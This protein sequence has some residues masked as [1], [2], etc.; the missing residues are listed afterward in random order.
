MVENEKKAAAN[1]KESEA[2]PEQALD[3]VAMGVSPSYGTFAQATGESPRLDQKLQAIKMGVYDNGAD[4]TG[5][6][7]AENE[8]ELRARMEAAKKYEELQNAIVEEREK[9]AE[10]EAKAD[11][12][13]LERADAKRRLELAKE[14]EKYSNEFA[15]TPAHEHVENAVIRDYEMKEAWLSDR[16]APIEH[17]LHSEFDKVVRDD[18]E[19]IYVT[20]KVSEIEAKDRALEQAQDDVKLARSA[21][22][23]TEKDK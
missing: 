7:A 9:R 11:P 1:E 23:K 5:E 20:P 8:D 4:P 3:A 13:E 10:A 2:A 12:F 14:Y 22:K 15:N 6:A 21:A 18:V 19:D 17:R 16:A